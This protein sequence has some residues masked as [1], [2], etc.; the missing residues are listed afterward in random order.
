MS[1]DSAIF[2]KIR[3]LRYNN[4][5]K[6]HFWAELVHLRQHRNVTE[7]AELDKEEINR[8]RSPTYADNRMPCGQMDYSGFINIGQHLPIS[9]KFGKLA[10]KVVR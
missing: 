1:K 8:R 5:N 3:P 9:V 7:K 2:R 10:G 4:C 6:V